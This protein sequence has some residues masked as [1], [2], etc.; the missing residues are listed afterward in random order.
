MTLLKV[1]RLQRLNKSKSVC[2]REREGE[3]RRQ[4]H[5]VGFQA[6]E[7]N[8]N[9]QR[10]EPAIANDERRLLVVTVGFD[11]KG[12][13]WAKVL[14]RK[15]WRWDRGRMNERGLSFV[16]VLQTY[17]MDW[18]GSRDEIKRTDELSSSSSFVDADDGWG[19]FDTN[20]RV[21]EW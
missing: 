4:T 15:R 20:E 11:Q 21:G 19:G 1:R 14:T 10:S 9:T 17:G 13:A 3:R 16:L 12:N 18:R 7:A 2:V 6:L 5:H 8:G